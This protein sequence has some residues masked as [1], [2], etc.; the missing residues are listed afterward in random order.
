M[1][2]KLIQDVLTVFFSNFRTLKSVLMVIQYNALIQTQSDRL[3]KVG[4]VYGNDDSLPVTLDTSVNI[5]R[6]F[7]KFKPCV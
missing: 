3:I 1:K 4:C 7:L 5:T 2:T 6:Y